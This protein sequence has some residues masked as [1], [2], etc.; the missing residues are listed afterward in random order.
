MSRIVLDIETTKIET[1]RKE[2]LTIVAV[3]IKEVGAY[4]GTIYNWNDLEERNAVQQFLFGFDGLVIGHNL[5][6]DVGVLRVNSCHMPKAKFYDT[7][8][9]LRCIN[10][11]ESKFS[12]KSWATYLG[13]P[14]YWKEF[15]E[16]LEYIPTDK[17]PWDKLEYYNKIDLEVTEDLFKYTE[18][19]LEKSGNR[20]AFELEMDILPLAERMETAGIP[21]DHEILKEHLVSLE[22][23]STKIEES[24]IEEYGPINLNSPFQVA[25]LLYDDI[26]LREIPTKGRS[27]AEPVLSKLRH[28][29]VKKLLARRKLAKRKTSYVVPMTAQ[30]IDNIL[31][32]DV[33]LHGTESGRFSMKKPALQTIPEVLR[34]V[35][36]P[37]NGM[38]VS[39]DLDQLEFKL[40]ADLAGEESLIK[41]IIKGRDVHEAAAS[42]MF[43]VAEVTEEQRSIAKTINYA[44]MYGAGI[45][46]IMEGSGLSWNKAKEFSSTF[47]I[48]LPMIMAFISWV[49][50]EVITSCAIDSPF[51][52]KREFMVDLDVAPGWMKQAI[53]REAVDFI[54]QSMGHDLLSLLWLEIERRIP[55]TVYRL[56][57]HDELVMDVL[58]DEVEDIKK[59]IQLAV[60]KIPELCY[61]RFGY[62]LEV[63]ITATIKSGY[64]WR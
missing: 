63:P 2:D 13:Y 57:L 28:R 9:A 49:H 46:T 14:P 55:G 17:M 20:V 35:F 21:V 60:D 38:F 61:D 41:A 7:M 44:K 37:S 11:E 6:F 24:I 3:G 22:E 18:E 51:G 48:T 1:N 29:V 12:L 42:T 27:T 33:R 47:E 23:D 32:A 4:E 56:E 31:Y 58:P 34:D 40:I 59:E 52:R 26:G 62:E 10:I 45:K 16:M 54:I 36:Y 8:I 64:K 43:G 15:E 53:K 39:A 19:R 5:M 25:K 30:A 50:R